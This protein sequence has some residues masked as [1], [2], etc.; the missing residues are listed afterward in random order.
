MIYTIAKVR[1]ENGE[2]MIAV[3][4]EQ[5]VNFKEIYLSVEGSYDRIKMRS[6]ENW[7]QFESLSL[8]L[9]DLKH[10]QLM[11]WPLNLRIL[12]L[13][14]NQLSDEIIKTIFSKKCP[15]LE[16][17]SLH[18]T[19]MTAQGVDILI[20]ISEWPNL[21]KLDI[22]ENQIGHEGLQILAS[23]NW[24]L[25]ENLNLR[26]TMI[27]HNGVQSMISTCKWSKLQTLDISRNEISD[28]R[29]G[30]LVLEKWPSL[31]YIFVDYT[32]VSSK[33]A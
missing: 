20:K 18:D 26:N 19:K 15:Q 1:S 5:W 17:L 9:S 8:S 3:Q 27:T 14:K 16:D 33:T 31:Q 29:I 21:K 23:G 32:E 25:L 2:C 30:A 28:R 13:S 6:R 4:N 11:I 7:D 12:N 10:I 24:P 22:S